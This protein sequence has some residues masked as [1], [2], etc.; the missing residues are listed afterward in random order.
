MMKKISTDRIRRSLIVASVFSIS[1]A[2]AAAQTAKRPELP[3]N[4]NVYVDEYPDKLMRVPAV[5]S[6]L[7]TLLGRRYSDFNLSISVQAPITQKGDFLLA[8][9]CIPHACTITEAAF[10]IDLKN[11]RIHAVLYEK[12]EAPRYFNEDKAPT[13]QVLLDWVAEL[14]AS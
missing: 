10:A 12:D 1:I 8:S 6:R 7:R 9:G 4:L 3:R 14:K 11:R 13:P 5:K 2:V